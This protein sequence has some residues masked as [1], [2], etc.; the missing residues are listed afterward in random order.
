M[1]PNG[2]IGSYSIQS[3]ASIYYDIISIYE[4]KYVYMTAYDHIY[5]YMQSKC[6]Q[7]VLATALQCIYS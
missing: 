1:Q 3:L 5:P 7:M 4:Q 6:T 2:A